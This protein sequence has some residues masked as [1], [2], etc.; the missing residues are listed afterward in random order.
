M[1]VQQAPSPVQA[2]RLS[3]DTVASAIAQLKNGGMTS[4]S[5]PSTSRVSTVLVTELKRFRR[6]QSKTRAGPPWGPSNRPGREVVSD[7]AVTRSTPSP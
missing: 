1:K 4:H 3:P 2:A 6:S 7:G 5:N